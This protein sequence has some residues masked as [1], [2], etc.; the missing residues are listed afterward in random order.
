MSECRTETQKYDWIRLMPYSINRVHESSYK[1]FQILREVKRL[2]EDGVPS[3][4][5]L[6]IVK[7][8]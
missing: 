8:L 5:V 7:L 2:L 3:H 1:S 4:I 6:E